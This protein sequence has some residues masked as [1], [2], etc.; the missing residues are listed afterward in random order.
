MMLTYK[1][2]NL[3]IFLLP[4][5]GLEIIWEAFALLLYNNI[6]QNYQKFARVK[7]ITR[8]IKYLENNEEIINN[9]KLHICGALNIDIFIKIFT[10]S[11]NGLSCIPLETLA[12]IMCDRSNIYYIKFSSHI[13]MLCPYFSII[14]KSKCHFQLNVDSYKHIPTQLQRVTI[15]T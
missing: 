8:N 2:R 5:D 3:Q 10:H 14:H 6:V 13:D 15:A 9:N 1:T 11:P 7:I 4:Q 12:R